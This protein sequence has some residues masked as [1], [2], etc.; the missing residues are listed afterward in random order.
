MFRC[1]NSQQ[2]EDRCLIKQK[3]FN[4]AIFTSFLAGGVYSTEQG[5]CVVA[6]YFCH[7]FA[8]NVRKIDAS[9]R[10]NFCTKHIPNLPSKDSSVIPQVFYLM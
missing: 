5:K 4:V 2:K 8:I 9:E 1:I 10:T 6:R 7:S 3:R